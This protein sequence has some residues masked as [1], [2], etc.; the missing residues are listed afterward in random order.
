MPE[1]TMTTEFELTQIL[2]GEPRWTAMVD[3]LKACDQACW[4]LDKD[5]QPLQEDLT[6]LAVIVNGQVVADLTLL[7]RPIEV[8]PSEWAGGRERILRNPAGQPLY[9]TFVQTFRVE[10]AH[11]R[12][13]YGRALQL[14]AL[15]VTKVLG[16]IQMRSWSSLDKPANYQLKF[17]LGFGFHP[18]IQQT[19]SGLQV[20]GGYFVKRV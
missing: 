16:C 6:F 5:D 8:P 3:Y 2:P 9:E 12:K 7:K 10:E 1:Y 19:A 15:R 17:S 20:S 4:V 11:R 14:E 13:G 18:D